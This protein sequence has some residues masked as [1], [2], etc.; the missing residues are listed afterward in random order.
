[1]SKANVEKFLLA[2]GKDKTLRYRYND[3][4]EMEKFVAQANADGYEFTQD[5]FIEF[6]KEEDLSFESTGNPR[7]RMIWLR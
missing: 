3:F 6:L 7:Q 5:E 4:E 2:G 1:M